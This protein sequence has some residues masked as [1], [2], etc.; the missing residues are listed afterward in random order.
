[1]RD[2]RGPDDCRRGV[3]LSAGAGEAVGLRGRLDAEGLNGYMDNHGIGR[4][5][6]VDRVNGVYGAAQPA[7]GGGRANNGDVTAN[8]QPGKKPCSGAIVV[9]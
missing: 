3:G 5:G 9:V 6:C 4:R 1:M 2:G 8:M 7:V